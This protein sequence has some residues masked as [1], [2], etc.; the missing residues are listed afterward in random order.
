MPKFGSHNVALLSGAADE[1]VFMLADHS[2]SATNT[3]T[4]RRRMPK[5]TGRGISAVTSPLSMAI[6]RDKSFVVGEQAKMGTVT[7]STVAHPGMDPAA[8]KAWL[9]SEIPLIQEEILKGAMTGDITLDAPA[10]G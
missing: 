10:G 7:V 6:R 8:F 3:I 2:I 5:T 9:A 1:N 4:L